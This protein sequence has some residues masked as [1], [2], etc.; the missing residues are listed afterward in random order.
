MI[1]QGTTPRALTWGGVLGLLGLG[2]FLLPVAPS[3]AQEE[4]GGQFQ[5]QLV[6]PGEAPPAKGADELQ[7]LKADLE[8]KRAELAQA[9]A[10][11]KAAQLRLEQA[12]QDLSKKAGGAGEKTTEKGIIILEVVDGDGKHVFK[13]PAG[14]RVIGAGQPP[15]KGE[16][17]IDV[18]VEAAKEK[19]MLIAELKKK[20]EAIRVE[21]EKAAGTATQQR[22]I[23]EIISDGK[24]QVIELPPGSHVL[25]GEKGKEIRVQVQ[26]GG[27]DN[28]TPPP[29]PMPPRGEKVGEGVY[30]L[31]PPPAATDTEKRVADL[32][33]RLEELM[34]AVKELHGE[35]NRGKPPVAPKPPTPPSGFQYYIP[36]TEAGNLFVP[37]P[38]TPPPAK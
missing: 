31:V 8:K 13:L 12:A 33:K 3:W 23:I 19:D 1:M 26:K 22:V 36:K 35:L 37:A 17:K 2:T 38:P 6:K 14:S 4:K 5:L 18:H 15:A 30:R 11:L 21:A 24:K 10:M 29:V 25:S 27:A 34:R 32:E 20:A 28:K 7:A 9:E 16:Q